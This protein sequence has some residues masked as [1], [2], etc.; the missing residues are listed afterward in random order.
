MSQPLFGSVVSIGLTRYLMVVVQVR[1]TAGI[2]CF[3]IK[4]ANQVSSVR[5]TIILGTSSEGIEFRCC[6]I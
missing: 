2:S 1:S 3:C 5:V 4:L 6:C